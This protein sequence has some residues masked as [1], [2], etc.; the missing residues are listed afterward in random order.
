M[1]VFRQDLPG[2]LSRKAAILGPGLIGGSLAMALRRGDVPWTVS[3]WTRRAG[4]L[5]A[6]ESVLPDCRVSCEL[7]S[8]VEGAEIVV[9][10]T[11]P[12]AIEQSGARLASLL[13]P[14]VP[15]TDAGSVKERI[16][17]VLETTLGGR[18]IGA[19]PMAG[20]EQSGIIAA[21]PDLYDGALC[22]L[23]PTENSEARALD[24]V[25]G[26]WTSAGCRL[27]EMSPSAHDA[28][29]AR[30]S[31]LPHAAAAALVHAA[32]ATDRGISALAG[33]GYRDSTRIACGPEG[34]W[35]EILLDNRKELVSGISDLQEHLE[36]LKNAVS[37]GDRGAIEG[38]LRTARILR[39]EDSP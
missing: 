4:S 23:T 20:S 28:A 34:L 36:A 38:F 2:S 17:S 5:A 29:V 30:M 16:V 37:R 25:R 3:L 7:A 6:V 24:A 35:A 31:H 13:P 21:R 22:I 8:V 26:L 33:S 32:L 14:G 9:L 10:C 19:H 18:F 15:V 12:H 11:S 27:H 39:A 1:P